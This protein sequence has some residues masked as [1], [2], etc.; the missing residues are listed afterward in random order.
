MDLVM[1]VVSVVATAV[2]CG[3]LLVARRSMQ[4]QGWKDFLGITMAFFVLV[5]A[6]ALMIIGEHALG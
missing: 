3:V 4:G 2:V 5:E 1:F 6:T